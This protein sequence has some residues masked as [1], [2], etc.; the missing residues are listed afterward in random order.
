[1]ESNG[2]ADEKLINLNIILDAVRKELQSKISQIVEENNKEREKITLKYN[3]LED[4]I[5]RLKR[6]GLNEMVSVIFSFSL[7]PN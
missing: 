7:V 4:E 5:L 1:M 2:V 3:E 6:H